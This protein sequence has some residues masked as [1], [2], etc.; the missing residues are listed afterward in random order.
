MGRREDGREWKEG[1]EREG[2][3]EETSRK[4]SA[5]K[6]GR[7]KERGVK[8]TTM[9]ARKGRRRNLVTQQRMKK[10]RKR[11][12]ERKGQQ[13]KEGVKKIEQ[14]YDGMLDKGRKKGVDI[15]FL[16]LLFFF[17]FFLIF[18]FRWYS[19]I[20]H[21]PTNTASEPPSIVA[22]S[23]NSSDSAVSKSLDLFTAGGILLAYKIRICRTQNITLN[24]LQSL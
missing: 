23:R 11:M 1:R 8:G 18:H 15:I 24:I 17:S 22:T 14:R 16:P 13:R 10:G 3:R 20:K 9:N 19:H 6:Q 2:G 7:V 5:R 4:K 12:S 21:K